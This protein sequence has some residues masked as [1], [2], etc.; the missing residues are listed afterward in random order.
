MMTNNYEEAIF[1]KGPGRVNSFWAV[2]SLCA[3]RSANTQEGLDGMLKVF[4]NHCRDGSVL[5]TAPSIIAGLLEL[6]EQL[7]V[8]TTEMM[9]QT[10]RE[11]ADAKA[12]KPSA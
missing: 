10:W 12:G 11:L 2:M 4:E 5:A 1:G 9:A 6:G 3:A 8:P 7:G